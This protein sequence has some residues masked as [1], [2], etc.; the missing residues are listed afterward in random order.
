VAL[1]QAWCQPG[2]QDWVARS[3]DRL[4]LWKAQQEALC[5]SLGW[6]CLPSAASFFCAQPA[7]ANLGA[8][9][10][11]LRHASIKL[12]DAASFGLPGHVRL[13][14]LP[15]PAQDALAKAWRMCQ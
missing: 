8:A 12:R 7:I 9:L 11:G 5:A 13:G 14:V 15:P 2:V 1:L 10:V 6:R 3:R 4:R